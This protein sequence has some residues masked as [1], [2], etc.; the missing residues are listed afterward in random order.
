MSIWQT[1]RVAIRA[2]LRNK[3]R[4]FLTALGIII[5]VGAVITMV[6]IGEG[7]KAQVQQAFAAMGSNLLVLLPGSTGAGGVSGGF[8]SQ[9]T[10][11]YTDLD[12][13]RG[14]VPGIRGVSPSLRK[15]GQVVAEDQ[16]WSTSI[17]GVSADYFVIRDWP[18]AHGAAYTETDDQGATKVAVLGQTV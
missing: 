3:L 9:P 16:N 12:A 7:A 6:A 18:M 2:L 1:V 8:G 13:I 10:L 17:Y 15:N 14:Q 4:S 11:T 5:G